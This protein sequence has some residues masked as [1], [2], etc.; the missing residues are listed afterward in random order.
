MPGGADQNDSFEKTEELANGIFLEPRVGGQ[1][2]SSWVSA[3]LGLWGPS[4][5]FGVQVHF[6]VAKAKLLFLR[7]PSWKAFGTSKDPHSAETK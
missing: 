4:T 1:A 5:T 3:C 6:P 7:R 2:W